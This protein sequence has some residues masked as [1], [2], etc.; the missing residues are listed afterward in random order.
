MQD[1]RTTEH[2]LLP[3]IIKSCQFPTVYGVQVGPQEQAE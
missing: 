2:G 1:V 3:P